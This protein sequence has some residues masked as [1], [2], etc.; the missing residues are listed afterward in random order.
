M[1]S[2]LSLTV[3]GR[4]LLR[5]LKAVRERL[6]LTPEQVAGRLGWHRSKLYRIEKGDSRL[7][8]N[9]LEELLDVYQVDPDEYQRLRELGRDA[10]KRGW[11]LGYRDVF[12]GDTFFAAEHDASRI[13]YLALY[14][15]PGLFQTAEHARALTRA[16]LPEHR[17]HIADRLAAAQLERQSLL[18]RADP[19][20]VV[21][22]LDEGLLHRPVGGPRVGAAQ[23]RR[24]LDVA[25]ARP[26]SLRVVPF[27]AGAHGG[28]AGP[29]TLLEFDGADDGPVVYREG[30]FDT[31]FSDH[32]ADL[33]RC[34]WALADADR[35]ALD[36]A[37]SADLIRTVARDW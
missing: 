4:R 10:F 26:V 14:Q 23:L 6:G 3:R 12:P 16:A 11:W 9:D 36:P 17:W 19:P 30:L 37:A 35:V 25:E 18:E 29:F 27:G 32:A 28:L 8:L 20:E 15:L 33:D 24:L 21:A 34:R 13:T 7:I 31:V 2:K 5:E 1:G 22:Y